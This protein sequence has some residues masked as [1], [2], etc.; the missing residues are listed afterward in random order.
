MGSRSKTNLAYIA[1]FLDGDGSL[2]M[3]IKKRTDG[4]KK[5]RFMLTICLYQDSRHD[6]PLWWIK[7]QFGI[8]YISKRKDHIT[9]LRINGFKQVRTILE[10]LLPYIRFKRKQAIEII[11]AARILEN[12][13]VSVRNTKKL[14]DCII[15][16][17]KNNYATK[18]KRSK[19]ELYSVLGLTP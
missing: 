12:R 13:K 17:Q 16:I 14:V 19:S 11:K 2:M 15:T 8:G 4:I 6:K 18:S 7:K 3:Q 1:G 10:E 9:E 5:F